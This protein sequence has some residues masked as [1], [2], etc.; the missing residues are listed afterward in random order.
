MS[1]HTKGMVC[2]LAGAVLWGFS[3]TCI[4]YLLDDVG[5]A[6]LA[7]TSIRTLIA[8]ILYAVLIYATQHDKIAML[9]HDPRSIGRIIVFGVFGLFCN[10]ASY[11]IAI[12]FTNSGTATV[13]SGLSIVF[14]MI[15]SCALFRRL[16]RP[17]DMGGL[18]L[19]MA[20]TFFIATKGDPSVLSIPAIGLFWGIMN[21]VTVTFYVMFPRK[22][23]ERYGS[24]VVIGGGM[25]TS[26]VFS[27]LVVIVLSALAAQGIESSM[28][29]VT[30]PPVSVKL[31]AGIIVI[32]VVGTFAAYGLFLHG[33][34]IVGGVKGTMLG[35]AE[36]VSATVFP[37]V[38][39]GTVFVWADWLGLA[40]MLGTIVL[41]GLPSRRKPRTNEK[42]AAT[43]R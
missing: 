40:L 31:V 9:A 3:G 29:P 18:V 37:A 34:S 6:P 8:G 22:T 13:L 19:A 15:I 14:V 16:P 26:G 32:S 12:G 1:L 23:I 24:I 28:F 25:L 5:L 21:A 7:L 35:A 2:T 17:Q 4:Q 42:R 30:I 39:L 20:A 33:I 27:T 43:E 10:Q 11:A 36:P 38:L 41:V